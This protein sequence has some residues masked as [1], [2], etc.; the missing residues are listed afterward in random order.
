MVSLTLASWNQTTALASR[1]RFT[2]ANGL[3]SPMAASEG[4]VHA[5]SGRR[6]FCADLLCTIAL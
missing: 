2:S 1:G 5:F 4:V 3:S 6:V